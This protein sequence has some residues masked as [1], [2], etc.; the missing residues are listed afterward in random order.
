MAMS[1][2][3]SLYEYEFKP[4]IFEIAFQCLRARHVQHEFKPLIF[5]IIF[6]YI[7]MVCFFRKYLE[8]NEYFYLDI[9]TISNLLEIISTTS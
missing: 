5:E 1:L 6:A 3:A 9:A 8:R 4:H 2:S 7:G